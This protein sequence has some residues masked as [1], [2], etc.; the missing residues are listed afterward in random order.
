M[1]KTILT[2][3]EHYGEILEEH[4]RDMVD[5]EFTVEN[6]KTKTIVT[7][8]TYDDMGNFLTTQSEKDSAAYNL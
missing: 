8:Y 3:L 2:E 4:F 7:T 5:I 1:K 6:D